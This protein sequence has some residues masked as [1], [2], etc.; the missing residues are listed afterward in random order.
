[1]PKVPNSTYPRVSD[2]DFSFIDT[3]LQVQEL[4]WQSRRLDQ[5]CSICDFFEIH[6]P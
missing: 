2:K 1:M 5:E 6:Y 3:A 4:A